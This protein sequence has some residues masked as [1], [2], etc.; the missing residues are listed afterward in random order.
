VSG[1]GEHV[2][3]GGE[4][5]RSEPGRPTARRRRGGRWALVLSLFLAGL[6]VAAAWLAITGLRA[7]AAL[8]RA[9]D[10]VRDSRRAVDDLDADA[11]AAAFDAAREETQ[12]AFDAVHDPL[13]AAWAAIPL[14]GD[15]ADAL[16]GLTEALVL[17]ADA[18][19]DLFEAAV[20][21]EPSSL[22]EGQAVRLDRVEAAQQPLSAAATDLA[23]ANDVLDQLPRS[24]A[25]AW[26]LTQVDDAVAQVSRQLRGA[27]AEVASAG[28]AVSVLPG[29]L[30][31]NGVRHWLMALQTPAEAR[32]TG[33]LVGTWVLLRADEGALQVVETGSNT[34][35]PVLDEVPVADRD[36]RLRY[37][38]DPR[39][40]QNVNLSAH[41]PF[42][43]VN[44]RAFWEAR[45]Q[46][47]PIDGV[48]ATDP[49]ALGYFLRATGPVELSDGRTLTS[50]NVARFALV[51]IYSEYPDRQQRKAF[52]EQ[53]AAQVFTALTSTDL[54]AGAAVRA[55][56]TSLAE[57]R[58]LAWSI[59]AK[60]QRLLEPYRVS[61]DL[62][63]EEQPSVHP[64]VLSRDGSKLNAY[65]ERE[66]S[67]RVQQCVGSAAAETVTVTLANTLPEAGSVD[68]FVFGLRGQAGP[69]GYAIVS[70]Q[71][72]LSG[73]S[74]T[75]SV[76][77]DGEEA[78][79]TPFVEVGRTSVLL[80]SLRVPGDGTPVTVR[81]TS[82]R[83]GGVQ[84]SQL[85]A[86][87]LLVEQ[88]LVIDAQVTSRWEPCE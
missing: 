14:L 15:N 22:L 83:P 30:G 85:A 53:V 34:D 64:V 55:L 58:L 69:D 25:G 61:G 54:R 3:G 74:Q 44:T 48:L 17:A 62:G 71:I 75:T 67:Y 52:Q 21:L 2:S 51:D 38:Q 32:G 66:M 31:G 4:Q 84:P 43:A 23:A 59:R 65:L 88:P 76:L 33:G 68:P 63:S 41:F 60:E 81:V 28:D 47:P 26:V 16:R 37:G 36:Y 86:E 87:P 46:G 42:T 40:F 13:W 8:E 11:S 12:T 80:E 70:L 45:G 18:G 79:H 50:D 35:F 1:G 39:L 20:A 77:L 27:E 56:R 57:G 19:E 24:A 72:H 49:V 82:T 29:M 10:A 5:R 78:G 73:E 7:V 6:L 9:E